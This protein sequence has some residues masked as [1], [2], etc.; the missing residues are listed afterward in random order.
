MKYELA[1]IARTAVDRRSGVW[2]SASADP[3]P[4]GGWMRATR[5]ALG[6][7]ATDFARRLGVSR[8]TAQTYE[9]NEID[10]AIQLATLRRAAEALECAFVYAFVPITSLEETVQ[11]NARR[12]ALRELERI[13]QTMLLED[14]RIDI[15]EF[16]ER[17]RE[18]T[19]EIMRSRRL[20]GDDEK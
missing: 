5:E 7:T 9:R 11:R 4:A 14:Q 18:R 17:L 2:R 8:Q 15:Q 6:M 16:N 1:K 10:G 19:E 3:R 20:W 12:K 13:D